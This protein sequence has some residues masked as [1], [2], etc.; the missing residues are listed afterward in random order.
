[1]GSKGGWGIRTP[2]S[3]TG[4]T[5]SPLS[6]Q[7]YWWRSVKFY[8]GALFS[9]ALEF[10]AWLLLFLLIIAFIQAE[11]KIPLEEIEEKSDGKDSRDPARRGYLSLPLNLVDEY[12]VAFVSG[13]LFLPA[14]LFPLLNNYPNDIQGSWLLWQTLDSS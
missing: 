5:V 10:F 2:G 9:L 3:F 11:W 7:H 13:L 14:V 4:E 12:P 6:P 8:S 1:M